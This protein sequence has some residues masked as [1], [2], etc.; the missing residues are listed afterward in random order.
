MDEQTSWY[1][2]KQRGDSDPFGPLPLDQLKQWAFGAQ[3]SPMDLISADGQTWMRAPMLPAL[4]MDWLVRLSE[5]QYYGP[6]TI[7]AVNEF[8][9]AGEIDTST[10]LIN[11]ETGEET[12]IRDMDL[13]VVEPPAP[14]KDPEKAPDQVLIGISEE[15]KLEVLEAA[16]VEERRA[17]RQLQIRYKKLMRLYQD[18]TGKEPLL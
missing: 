15:Q 2:K 5:D 13:E 3:I 7:G 9:E 12:F 17:L 10:R 14:D 8:L 4:E 18:A 6:T 1:L 11:C 16:L